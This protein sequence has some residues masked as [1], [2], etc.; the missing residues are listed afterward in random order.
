M[1]TLGLRM[2]CSLHL[3]ADFILKDIPSDC[4]NACL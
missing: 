2:K 3:M 1:L 4:Q